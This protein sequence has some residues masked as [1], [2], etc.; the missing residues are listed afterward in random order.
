MCVI[1]FIRGIHPEERRFHTG[2]TL[3]PP[4]RQT[5][6]GWPRNRHRTGMHT[7]SKENYRF[8]TLSV[9]CTEWTLP[10]PNSVLVRE[11]GVC[12]LVMCDFISVCKRIYRNVMFS[13]VCVIVFIGEYIQKRAG[14]IW[15]FPPSPREHTVNRRACNRHCSVLPTQISYFRVKRNYKKK[16]EG[17]D[18]FVSITEW[19]VSDLFPVKIVKE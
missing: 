12:H 17:L 3:P 5:G 4:W 19:I 18:S 7:C 14:S 6:N 11:R 13:W 10:L 15:D 2:S 8:H 1:L 9:M 16:F